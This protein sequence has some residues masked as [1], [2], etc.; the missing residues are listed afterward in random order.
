MA[1]W[2]GACGALVRPLVEALLHYVLPPGKLHT[3]DTTMPVLAP[4]NG[5]NRTAWMWVYVRD[6]RRPVRQR[7]RRR[8]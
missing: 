4:G 8:G 5:Q 7:H 3:D 6:D 1:R 2:I